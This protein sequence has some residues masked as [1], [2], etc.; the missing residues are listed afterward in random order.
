MRKAPKFFDATSQTNIVLWHL[1]KF[2]TITSIEAFERY[3]ITRL[4]AQTF[5]LRQEGHRIGMRWQESVNRY[6][7]PVRYGVYFLEKRNHHEHL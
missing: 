1:T 2:K 6:G 5:V 3:G 7:V 4:S